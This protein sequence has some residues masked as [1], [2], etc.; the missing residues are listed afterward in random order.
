MVGK[1]LWSYIQDEFKAQGKGH[2]YNKAAV[3]ICTYSSFFLGG[4]KAM[5]NGILE[6]FRTLLG[7]TPKEFREFPSQP[8]LYEVARG[9]AEVM[10]DSEVIQDFR[11]ISRTVLETYKGEEL[12]GPTGQALLSSRGGNL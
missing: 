1:G 6:Y 2:L 11:E 12:K 5:V 10:Q 9:V 3:K 4:N 7:M 8:A